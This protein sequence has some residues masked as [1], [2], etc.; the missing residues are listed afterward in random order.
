MHAGLLR[1]A[2]CDFTSNYLVTLRKSVT[3]SQG[4]GIFCQRT[5]IF[6]VR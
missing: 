4:N 6:K 1:P 3:P 5:V 2:F